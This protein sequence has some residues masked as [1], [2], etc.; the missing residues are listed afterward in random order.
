LAEDPA[1][2][3]K[4]AVWY[5]KLRVQPNVSDWN[6]VGSVTKPINPGM[7][8][9]DDREENFKDYMELAQTLDTTAGTN[10]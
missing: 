5:W 6:D 3:A 7:R 9:L 1:V 10:I 4:I 2:A 8:G